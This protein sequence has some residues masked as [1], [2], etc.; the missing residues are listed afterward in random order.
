MSATSDGR[1]DATD[2][3]GMDGCE[4][5]G[6]ETGAVRL[7]LSRILESPAFAASPQLRSFLTYIVERK[8]QGEPERIKGYTIATEALGRD[9]SFDPSA[10]PIVRVEAARLR[11]MLADYFRG[12]GVRDPIRVDIPKGGYIPH[13][14]PAGDSDASAAPPAPAAAIRGPHRPRAAYGAAGAFF[15]MIAAFLVY[16]SF[17]MPSSSPPALAV[18]T[19]HDDGSGIPVAA[20]KGDLPVVLVAAIEED[21]A[22]RLPGGFSGA[23]LRDKLAR[24]LYRFDEI[25][26]T[27]TADAADYRLEG[28]VSSDQERL[29]LSFRLVYLASGEIVWSSL[30][31]VASE[32]ETPDL[33]QERVARNAATAIA[34]PY[35]VIFNHAASRAGEDGAQA[36]GTQEGLACVLRTFSAQRR[37]SADLNARSR[38]CLAG[39]AAR[40]RPPAA[41]HALLPLAYAEDVRSGT[42]PASRTANLQKALDLARRAVE[43]APQSARAHQALESV[44]VLL[45]RHEEAL[46][47]GRLALELNPNDP[48]IIATHGG[49]LVMSGD[50]EKGLALLVRA[51]RL[52]PDHPEWYTVMT[53]FGALGA[54]K[55]KLAEA[56]AESLAGST[57]LS[58]L[59]ARLLVAHEAGDG[60]RA[61]A[62]MR[63][64]DAEFPDFAVDPDPTLRAVLPSSALRARLVG[65]V[66]AAQDDKR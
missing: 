30:F 8:L 46:A 64:L 33:V 61:R 45:G 12:P 3:C 63:A 40:R 25:G 56:E 24:A 23:A 1:D 16:R 53:V 50:S 14:T 34:Q 65:A 36:A 7:E 18:A 52:N 13:F 15:L 60:A 51:G 58:A 55:S 19:V 9:A 10:D 27:D 6:C 21:P 44:L 48:D 22:A 35:G 2:G 39:L 37:F 5:D 20:F 54:G 57:A 47:A 41:I 11:R 4:M 38:A 28:H 66:R 42:D 26:V 31:D 29:F 32:G 49:A 59:L 17:E 43:I 62:A